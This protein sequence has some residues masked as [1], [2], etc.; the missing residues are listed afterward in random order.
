MAGYGRRLTRQAGGSQEGILGFECVEL[1]EVVH[2]LH[3]EVIALSIRHLLSII[4]QI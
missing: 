2:K 1:P 4:C 3:D